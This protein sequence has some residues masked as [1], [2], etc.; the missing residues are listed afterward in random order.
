M[1]SI[2]KFHLDIKLKGKI[3]KNGCSEICLHIFFYTWRGNLALSSLCVCEMLSV[4]LHV[5]FKCES[6]HIES[7]KIDFYCL[8]DE[9][10]RDVTLASVS[11]GENSVGGAWKEADF[12]CFWVG[13]WIGALDAGEE[14]LDVELWWRRRRS[15]RRM[16]ELCCPSQLCFNTQLSMWGQIRA[17]EHLR[18]G[19]ITCSSPRH[20]ESCSSLT[21]LS[22]SDRDLAARN[23]LVGE[24][25][26]VK[27]SDF[28]M[29]RER[30]DG[31]YSAEGGLRQIPVKWTAPEALN[32]GRPRLSCLSNYQRTAALPRANAA[33]CC[34]QVVIPL[35]VTCGALGSYCGRPFPWE[36]HRT[37]AW[38]TSRLGT[39]WSEVKA[40]I[41]REEE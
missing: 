29:S 37:R 17:A 2:Y 35:R 8:N 13:W 23:C 27:I 25:N 11:L 18:H 34:H 28:G 5:E 20:T 19:S 16:E 24:H 9:K 21:L 41:W 33:T 12:S 32:Y 7:N 6:M 36:W 14:A 31:I 3:H 10:S 22:S 30:D 15:R 38:T 1:G 4:N 26:V 39:R 40:L